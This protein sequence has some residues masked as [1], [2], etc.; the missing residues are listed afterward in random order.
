M[1]SEQNLDALEQAILSTVE[2]L[3]RIDEFAL[4]SSQPDNA[5]LVI[6]LC[7]PDCSNF[8]LLQSEPAPMRC[9]MY[10][11][12]LSL[13]FARYLSRSNELMRG[14][15]TLR[16]TSASVD[17]AVPA[18]LVQQ[19]VDIGKSPDDFTAELHARVSRSSAAVKA[20]QHVFRQME[21]A[22]WSQA[23]DLLSDEVRI[24]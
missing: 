4:P 22:L 8:N 12:V 9:C 10:V 2:T 5:A 16:A 20:K 3:D 21:E 13:T 24:S 7:A 18:E 23:G 14:I 11:C 17:L 19:H 6:N 1:G 15:D